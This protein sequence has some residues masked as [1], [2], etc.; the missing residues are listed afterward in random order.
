MAIFDISLPNVSDTY[1]AVL[2]S[3]GFI[4]MTEIVRDLV[5]DKLEF[6]HLQKCE[7]HEKLSNFDRIVKF[8]TPYTYLIAFCYFTQYMDI[9]N[10]NCLSDRD[11]ALEVFTKRTPIFVFI[12]CIALAVKWVVDLPVEMSEYFTKY[13]PELS[14]TSNI[15]ASMRACERDILAAIDFNCHV[16]REILASLLVRYT[17]LK[18]KKNN[19]VE[20]NNNNNGKNN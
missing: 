16:S 10:S 4:Y 13:A 2:T 3:N 11:Q 20:N 14:P 15:K 5:S 6:T 18:E 7:F 1:N 8:M 17:T 9:T 19:N 12:V